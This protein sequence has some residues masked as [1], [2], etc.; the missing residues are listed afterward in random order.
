MIIAI[1]SDHGGYALK[2]KIKEYLRER[3]DVKIVDLG[4]NS[5]ESVDYPVYGKACGEAVASGKADRG[6]VVCGTGIG[7]SIAANKVKG[8]RCGLC[9]SVEMARLTRQHNNANMLAL[10]G[11]TTDEELAIRITETWLDTEFEGGRHKRRTDMLD[12]M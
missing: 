9:T 11:R 12:N 2:E 8:I 3:E 6:I 4:T 5:E 1:A 10:G 7:I